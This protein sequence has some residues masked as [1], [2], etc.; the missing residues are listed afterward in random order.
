VARPNREAVLRNKPKSAVEEIADFKE[1]LGVIV[2]AMSDEQLHQAYE[3]YGREPMVFVQRE[4]ARR[5][6]Q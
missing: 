6:L 1:E 4:I 5:K 3:E 2:R